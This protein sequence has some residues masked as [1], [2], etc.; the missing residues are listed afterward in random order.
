MISQA[1]VWCMNAQHG[2]RDCLRGRCHD[3]QDWHCGTAFGMYPKFLI[4]KYLILFLKVRESGV[5]HQF[6]K[7]D[8]DARE[9]STISPEQGRVEVWNKT[10][11]LI[12][13]KSCTLPL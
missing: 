13:V 6:C 8:S 7:K 10:G 4:A 11:T 2:I 1:V 9:L 3:P 5:K 12:Y